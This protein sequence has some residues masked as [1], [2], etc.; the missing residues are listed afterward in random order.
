MQGTVYGLT[1]QHTVSTYR[2]P[3]G[4]VQHINNVPYAGVTYVT[5]PMYQQVHV[6]EEYITKHRPPSSNMCFRPV[7]TLSNTPKANVRAQPKQNVSR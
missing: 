3:L 7:V 1:N 6:E 5:Q 2:Q 4:D